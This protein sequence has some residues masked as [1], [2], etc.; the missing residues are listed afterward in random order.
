M[1]DAKEICLDRLKYAILKNHDPESV[2]IEADDAI[3]DF[4]TDLGYIEIVELYDQVKK[5]G[6]HNY[7]D[8]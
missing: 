6:M 4:L 1:F 8:P 3:I 5:N 2:H 7:L